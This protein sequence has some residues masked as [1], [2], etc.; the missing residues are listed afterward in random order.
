MCS[1]W[2]A[3][4]SR[5]PRRLADCL[6]KRPGSDSLASFRSIHVERVL[7]SGV[8]RPEVRTAAD[9]LERPEERREADALLAWAEANRRVIAG[10]DWREPL[11]EARRRLGTHADGTLLRSRLAA[12]YAVVLV[13]LG[14]AFASCISSSTASS[15]AKP[16]LPLVAAARHCPAGE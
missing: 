11:V 13:V 10:G 7:G 9:D 14:A 16:R 1:S 3:S 4:A 8:E 5:L 6:P 15:R 2:Q 12:G